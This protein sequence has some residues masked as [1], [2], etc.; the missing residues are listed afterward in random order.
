MDDSSIPVTNAEFIQHHS[1]TYSLE[2]SVIRPEGV[3]E[4]AVE[5][6]WGQI[7]F[8]CSALGARIKCC[9]TRPSRP[10]Y[11]FRTYRD[12]K[13]KQRIYDFEIRCPNSKCELN[14]I[15]WQAKSPSG[16]AIG[17]Q[18]S[19]GRLDGNNS[20]L[21][22]EVVDCW[23]KDKSN[24]YVARGCPIPAYTVDN[25]IYRHL[26]QLIIA[27][28]DKFARMSFEPM[29]GGLFGNVTHHHEIFGFVRAGAGMKKHADELPNPNA[30]VV[31]INGGLES[32]SLII[33]DELHLIEGP[34]GS[35]TGFY[36]TVVEE[37]IREGSVN[38]TRPKYIAST[39]T[40]RSANEQIR[41]LFDRQ[42]HLFPPKGPNWKDRG[43][44]IENDTELPHSIGENQGRL[45]MGFC[46]I[47]VSALGVQ[48]RCICEHL[49]GKKTNGIIGV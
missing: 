13:N 45:Y 41:S 16:S 44:L 34:L 43:L 3:D 7:K 25:Q 28:A 12:A 40:I 20:G 10:G 4:Q 21:P 27:T 35:M 42:V 6:I 38:R 47:G 11:F 48:R 22:V 49:L 30:R 8:S 1:D 23:R 32:P 18:A 36:E 9:S 15:D 14:S 31:E 24:P 29:T 46:P 5:D 26:P 19:T 2:L 39:A 33:Q 17:R 37:L